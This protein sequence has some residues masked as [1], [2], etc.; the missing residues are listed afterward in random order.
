VAK[1]P[2]IHVN[3]ELIAAAVEKNA[4]MRELQSAVKSRYK[5]N[6]GTARAFAEGLLTRAVERFGAKYLGEMA[7]RITQIFEN[8]ERAAAIVDEVI[9]AEAVSPEEAGRRLETLF[10]DI[11]QD[12][13]AITS[14]EEYAKKTKIEPPDKSELKL[15]PHDDEPVSA[16]KKPLK[17]GRHVEMLGLLRSKFKEMARADRKAIRKAADLAPAELWRAV[18]SETESGQARNIEALKA[19]CKARGMGPKELANLEAAVERLSLERARSQR[20][21]GTAEALAR[22]EAVKKLPSKL[23]T[24]VEGDR[25]LELLALENPEA[26]QDFFA[27]SG[28]KSRSA[29]RSYIRRRM[30]AH[31]RGLL[32][33]FTAA[34]QLGENLIML[35]GPD[36]NVT[37]PGTDLVG[38][39][40]DGRIWLIDNKALSA[41]ELGSVS[42]L[43]QNVAKNVEDDTATFKSEFGLKKDPHIGD[44]VSRLNKATKEIKAITNG[45]T[46]Q[47]VAAPKIQKQIAAI[48]A[49]HRIERVITNA[50]GAV[51]GLSA[52][53]LKAKIRLEDLNKPVGVDPKID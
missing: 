36:Y 23:R 4:S 22:A 40:R 41:E 10:K 52:G 30:V 51:D 1:P 26:L 43:I 47:E 28:A 14:P 17:S 49:E 34:F 45:L 2:A 39:T 46:P 37:I 15:T 5:T 21:P 11:K 24:L 27:A 6:D 29:L 25:Q 31:I 19:R 50:G 12:V 18:A 13:E 7:E 16:P 20:V 44:A 38:V 42:S 32:G 9:G 3:P 35:K 48:L 53:L 33:E 8:R